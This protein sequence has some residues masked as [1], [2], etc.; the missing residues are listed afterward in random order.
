M[1]KKGEENYVKSKEKID[2]RDVLLKT[3]QKMLPRSGPELIN[4]DE[5]NTNQINQR[6]GSNQRQQ[7]TH[8]SY[9][10]LQVKI[11]QCI[12]RMLA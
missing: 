8:Q 1:R 10:Q 9:H 7:S 3:K 5:S 6:R 11:I 12:N 4:S 2:N